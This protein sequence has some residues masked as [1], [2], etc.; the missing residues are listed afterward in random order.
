MAYGGQ[1]LRLNEY[2]NKPT[3]N[4]LLELK[5]SAE[6]VRFPSGSEPAL[7]HPFNTSIVKI[8]DNGCI[9]IFCGTNVGIRL[10]PNLANISLITDGERHHT[11]YLREWIQKDVE[12]HVGRNIL[13]KIGGNIYLE[14][15]GNC[16]VNI[17]G[18]AD[19]NIGGNADIEIG[20][21][22]KIDNEGTVEWMSGG[23]MYFAAPNYF[24]S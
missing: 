11:G 15:Q 9:D 4:P 18:N 3:D 19:L 2:A 7:T 6:N 12:R 23:N 20:G 1:S 13:T 8:R 10:D 22:V 5:Q 14:A 17:G 16:T 24:F 21:N